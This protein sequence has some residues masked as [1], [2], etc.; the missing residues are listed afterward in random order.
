MATP[1]VDFYLLT[2]TEPEQRLLIA[3]KL[4]E[5]AYRSQ[6]HTF[7]LTDNE[8]QAHA[9]DDLLWTYNDISFL[10]HQLA[11]ESS[12]P[13]PIEIGFGDINIKTPTILLNLSACPAKGYQQFQRVIEIILGDET[14][15]ALGR[16][17][18]RHY[19]AVGCELTTHNI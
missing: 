18:Y 2:S 14:S 6:Q 13:A 7:I 1:R 19:R 3:C 10:P 4:A 17:H 9:M 15:K 5:K 8:R 16:E 12:N 11:D